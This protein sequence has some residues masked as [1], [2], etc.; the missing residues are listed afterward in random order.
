ML[1]QVQALVLVQVQ[2]LESELNFLVIIYY[3]FS[4]A[5]VES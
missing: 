2:A 4:K 3:T 5:D 1:V